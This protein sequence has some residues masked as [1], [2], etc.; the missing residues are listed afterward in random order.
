MAI[1]TVG[2]VEVD[3][4][5]L[6]IDFVVAL[7]RQQKESCVDCRVYYSAGINDRMATLD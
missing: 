4:L 1:V 3:V 5:K 6:S 7:L 2:E